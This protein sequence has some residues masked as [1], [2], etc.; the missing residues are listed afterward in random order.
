LPAQ[1]AHERFVPQGPTTHEDLAQAQ[2]IF[3]Q[4][5]NHFDIGVD[6]AARRQNAQRAIIL[7]EF[8]YAFDAG[9][10]G[11]GLQ[12]D[13]ES[14]ITALGIHALRVGQGVDQCLDPQNLSDR[15]Q[16]ADEGHRVHA[17]AQHVATEADRDVPVVGVA[18]IDIVFDGCTLRC[19]CI[20]ADFLGRRFRTQISRCARRRRGC[21]LGLGAEV[22][23]KTSREVRSM[24][25]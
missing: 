23:G 6:I 10:V 1:R 3:G 12:R 16:I 13:L 9:T 2:I 21:V 15:A 4:R 24:L 14:Q 19:A 17:I 7:Y 5:P 11:V 8:E 22:P 25:D 18:R 20:A